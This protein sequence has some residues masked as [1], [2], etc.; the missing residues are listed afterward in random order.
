MRL[1]GSIATLRFLRGWRVMRLYRASMTL[2]WNEK[3]RLLDISKELTKELADVKNV[4]LHMGNVSASDDAGQVSS[5]VS[6][7]LF[8]AS[9]SR[10]FDLEKKDSEKCVV[11]STQVPPRINEEEEE[12]KEE[13]A[14]EEE[15]EEEEEDYYDSEEEM[16]VWQLSHKPRFLAL[17]N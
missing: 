3:R 8:H 2:L 15:E 14:E 6:R 13:Q 10:L 16:I 1:E 7:M 17:K 5:K 4:L 11:V 12:K 9:T